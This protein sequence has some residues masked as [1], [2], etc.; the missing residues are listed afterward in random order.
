MGVFTPRHR[1]T[2]APNIFKTPS[3]ASRNAKVSTPASV[4]GTSAKDLLDD[5]YESYTGTTTGTAGGDP[6]GAVGVQTLTVSK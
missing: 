2:D 1:N 5:E 6:V 3:D 4:I